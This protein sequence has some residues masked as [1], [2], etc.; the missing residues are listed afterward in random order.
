MRYIFPL[1]FFLLTLPISQISAQLAIGGGIAY[2]TNTNDVGA[3]IKSQFSIGKRW[4]AEASFDGYS[5][6]NKRSFYGDFN[7]NA[8]YIYA[9]AGNVE[10]H[11]LLGGVVFFWIYQY[12]RLC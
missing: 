2:T 10:L 3:Q 12:F 9:D 8:N 6:G 1:L 4:R 7:L 11:A 5:T